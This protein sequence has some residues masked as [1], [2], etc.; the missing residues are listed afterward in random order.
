MG[1]AAGASYTLMRLA[2]LVP[3]EIPVE[4]WE[5]NLGCLDGR[6]RQL[7]P[8][9][10]VGI[11]SKTLAIE[12]AERMAALAHQAGV[13]AVVVGGAHATLA[14]EDVAR[15]ADVVVT[16]EA[17]SHLAAVDPG[18]HPRPFAAPLSRQQL[19]RSG[20]RGAH[21]RP[22]DSHGGREPSLLDAHDGDHARMPAQLFLLHGD[23]GQRPA[24]AA[25]AH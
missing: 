24:D 22:C 3:P 20:R 23:S 2:S 17:Y 15:W 11:T 10:L 18:F 14:P 19:G 25:A 13:Q 21:H 4:I 9:D 7:G 1:R 6:L 5:E 16:G 12:S 8:Q